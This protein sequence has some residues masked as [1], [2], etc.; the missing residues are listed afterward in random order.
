MR[1]LAIFMA[2]SSTLLATPANAR[3]GAWYIG[4]DVGAVIADDTEL[5][6]G[7]V[8]NAV[9]LDHDLGYD[10][11]L[12]GGYDFGGFRLEAEAAYKNVSLGSFETTIRLPGE[13]PAFPAS[14]DSAEGSTRAASFMIDAMIDIGDDDGLSAFVGG[15]LGAAWV[16][17]RN[18]AVFPTSAAFLD[19]SD[20]RFAW[21][22]LAGARL[23]VSG[24]IDLTARYRFFNGG[25]NRLVAFNGNETDARF[26]SHSLLAGIAFNFGGQHRR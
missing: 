11:A 12:V 26:R 24:N 14:R 5:D 13:G 2:L 18:L 17:Y 16:K 21:Q 25:G 1:T 9:R 22:L 8:D 6:I 15:G 3:N 7:N 19:A 4:G 23:P 10:A 20:V